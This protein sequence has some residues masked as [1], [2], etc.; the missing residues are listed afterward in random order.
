MFVLVGVGLF[1]QYTPLLAH[2]KPHHQYYRLGT[3]TIFCNPSTQKVESGK[4]HSW[5]HSKFDHSVSVITCPDQNQFGGERVYFSLQS[6]VSAHD[7]RE[8]TVHMLETAVSFIHSR[9]QREGVQT[10]MLTCF[11]HDIYTHTGFWTLCLGND[12]AH[13]GLI[14]PYQ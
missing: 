1:V 7:C 10:C 4:G 2:M 12:G 6:Q 14:L 3:M 5:P 11:Q 9:D 13:S 8:A